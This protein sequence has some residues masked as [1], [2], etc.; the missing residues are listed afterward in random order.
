MC[1]YERTFR[2]SLGFTNQETLKKYFKAKD[3][4]I[5]NWEKI[6]QYNIRLKD[7]CEKINTALFDE[8][9]IENIDDITNKIDEAFNIMRDN[10]IIQHLNNQG[11]NP[12]DVYYNWMR[13]Y[14]VCEM[15]VPAI[16]KIFD[17]SI[18]EISHIGHDD[19]TNLETF[20]RAATAD[21]EVTTV[22]GT[23][24]RL[25]MQSGYTGIN[26][27]KRSKII[28]AINRKNNCLVQLLCC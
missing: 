12:E 9:K 4:R 11:R 2:T 5:I 1:N 10:N 6:N 16:A 26:D 14:L 15:F 25:E 24:V 19:L 22:D 8:I 7:I 23:K 28:E 21:L 3:L 27:I 17:I 18:S 13:G 20:T